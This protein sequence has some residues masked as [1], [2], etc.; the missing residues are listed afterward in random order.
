MES[1]DLSGPDYMGNAA[2]AFGAATMAQQSRRAPKW[3]RW[4]LYVCIGVTVLVTG[5]GIIDKTANIGSLPTCDAKRTRDTLSD[6]NKA[7]QLNATAYNFIKQ[8]SAS[9]SE[10]KCTANLALKSGTVEYDYRIYKEDGGIKVQI[11]EWRR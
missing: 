7:N 2:A 8:V 3:V 4:F 9:E 10:V 6:L 5:A 1:K 11:T